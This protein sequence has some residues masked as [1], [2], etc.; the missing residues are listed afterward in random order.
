M[1]FAARRDPAHHLL[2]AWPLR[3]SITLPLQPGGLPHLS[4]NL[5]GC[6]WRRQVSWAVLPLQHCSDR[7]MLSSQPMLAHAERSMHPQPSSGASTTRQRRMYDSKCQ[8]CALVHCRRPVAPTKG[9]AGEDVQV[10]ELG[11]AGTGL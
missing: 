11:E 7:N 5:L 2:I 9:A 1:K 6:V 3:P 8:P 10:Q 4:Q